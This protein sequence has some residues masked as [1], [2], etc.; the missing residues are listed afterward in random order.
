MTMAPTVFP[1]RHGA[2]S[3]PPIWLT[4]GFRPFF[5]SAALWSVAALALWIAMLALGRTLPSRFD[6]LSWHIHEMLFGF[7]LAAAA[8]F[9]LTAVPNWTRRLPVAGAPLAMLFGLWLLGRLV[10]AASALLPAWFA[11]L[12]DLAFPLVLIGVIAREIIAGKNWR[13]LAMT[14]P[15]L[16]LTAADLAMHLEA[17]GV[18]VPAGLGWRLG[19]AAMIILM[20]IIGGRI[21]PSFTRN[22]LAKRGSDLTP[23]NPW[24]TRATVGTL[25]AGL[26]GWSFLPESR[27]FGGLLVIGGGLTFWR[28]GSWR[29]LAT[30]AEPLLFI[31]HLG[32]AWLAVGVL[33][34]GLA[35]LGPV[36]LPAAIHALTAGAM[37]TMIL[38][39]MT[40]VTRGHSGQ[41]LSADRVTIAIYLLVSFAALFRVLAA[42]VMPGPSPL[43]YASAALWIAAFVLF[44]VAYGPMLLFKRA[45]G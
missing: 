35:V 13:N 20:S 33:L 18:N 11:I 29:G 1:T 15:L 41:D 39:V 8:G 24:L 22:W 25:H 21:I 9:L 5:L 32:Y 36:P 45:A 40:R 28:L 7:G 31:L 37:G 16:V 19:L 44:A 34:L 26:I 6:P 17:V 4:Q 12:L 38:A 23:Q 3:W 42:F 10:C 14:A 30:S 43:L 27:L 2:S